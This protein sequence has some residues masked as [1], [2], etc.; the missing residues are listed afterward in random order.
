MIIRLADPLEDAL[1]LLE[2]AEDFVSRMDYTDDIPK[3]PIKFAEALSG[4]IMADFSETAVAEHEG[5]IVAMII[6]GYMPHIWNPDLIHA[7]ELMWWADRDAPKT[8]GI[9]LLKYIKKRAK[10]KG[11][12][13]ITFTKLTSSPEKVGSVYERM[14]LREV[15]TSYCGPV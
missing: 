7:E 1:E 6:M 3:D 13:L 11:A 12:D 2:A 15:E 8:A 10:E 14:G 9:R 4:V 5:K